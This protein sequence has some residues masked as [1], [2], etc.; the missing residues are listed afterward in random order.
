MRTLAKPSSEFRSQVGVRSRCRT[1]SRKLVVCFGRTKFLCIAT[2]RTRSLDSD[3]GC[4]EAESD[5]FPFF[6]L[7]ASDFFF[8]SLD[9]F[10]PIPLPPFFIDFFVFGLELMLLVFL[11]FLLFGIFLLRLLLK[12]D[13]A[14]REGANELTIIVEGRRKGEA[15]GDTNVADDGVAVGS[16]VSFCPTGFGVLRPEGDF[17][18]ARV[19]IV[20]SDGVKVRGTG[21]K[22]TIC[23]EGAP[24]IFSSDGADVV[25]NGAGVVSTIVGDTVG[26]VIGKVAA[27]GIVG[28]PGGIEEGILVGALFMGVTDG[29]EVKDDDVG[30][31]VG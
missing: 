25:R 2:I 20:A 16:T 31:W 19:L 10:I 15:L 21:A 29:K 24:V 27:G 9:D 5:S 7:V 8:W 12:R 17:V 23:L 4:F 1:S 13:G 28:T 3:A 11:A 26:E 30:A 22:V 14:V 18:G 6:L